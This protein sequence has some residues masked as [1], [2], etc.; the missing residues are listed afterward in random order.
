MG[1]SCSTHAWKPIG[2]HMHKE[3]NDIKIDG[4][5]VKQEPVDVVHNME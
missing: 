3:E 5:E 2:L 4:T 1:R